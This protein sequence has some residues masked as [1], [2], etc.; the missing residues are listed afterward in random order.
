MK[1]GEIERRG[2]EVVRRRTHRAQSTHKH[3]SYMQHNTHRHK[4]KVGDIEGERE[5]DRNTRA[6]AQRRGRKIFEM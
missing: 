6:V 5:R 3:Y 4:E 2:G 1:I